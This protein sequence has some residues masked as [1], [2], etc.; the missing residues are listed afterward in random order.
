MSGLGTIKTLVYTLVCGA[1]LVNLSSIWPYKFLDKNADYKLRSRA[2]KGCIKDVNLRKLR[3]FS[4]LAGGRRR[5][6]A[7]C[8]LHANSLDSMCTYTHDAR[9]LW[10]QF[11]RRCLTK[12]MLFR[13]TCTPP[14]ICAQPD[15]TVRRVKYAKRHTGIE[16]ERERPYWSRA[17]FALCNCNIHYCV[18]GGGILIPIWLLSQE[19]YPLQQPAASCNDPCIDGQRSAL[20]ASVASKVT[21]LQFIQLCF[22]QSYLYFAYASTTE[23]F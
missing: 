11:R 18:R 5:K 8:R 17:L 7:R 6:F 23:S 9:Y 21:S 10:P 14:F 15:K 22:M 12:A 13:Y 3:G 2:W 20:K 1:E 4:R 19:L 16:R